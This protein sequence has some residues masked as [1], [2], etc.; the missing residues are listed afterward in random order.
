[1]SQGKL[2]F[3]KG[4]CAPLPAQACRDRAAARS[5]GAENRPESEAILS[6]SSDALVSPSLGSPQLFLLS[7]TRAGQSRC[8]LCNACPWNLLLTRGPHRDF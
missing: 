7:K 2:R 6:K 8:L 1:M 4:F 5:H 3:L